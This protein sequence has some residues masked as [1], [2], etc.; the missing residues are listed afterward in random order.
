[1]TT[2]P[3]GEPVGGFWAREI[4]WKAGEARLQ[5]V[6]LKIRKREIRIK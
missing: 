5:I 2:D 1:M 4:G 3:K 6:E